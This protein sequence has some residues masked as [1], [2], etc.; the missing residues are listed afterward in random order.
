MFY[1]TVGHTHTSEMSFEKFD[2]W[3]TVTLDG[4]HGVLNDVKV[5]FCVAISRK[6]WKNI[7]ARKERRRVGEMFGL[8][9]NCF[10]D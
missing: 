6:C 9:I 3:I 5:I 10:F 4:P 1:S 7:V 2:R 8:A